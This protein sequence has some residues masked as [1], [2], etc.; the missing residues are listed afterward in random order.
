VEG[1]HDAAAKFFAWF[2][3]K[4]SR[5]SSQVNGRQRGEGVSLGGFYF[6]DLDGLLS[7]CFV[8]CCLMCIVLVGCFWSI[9]S[10]FY[11]QISLLE[12]SKKKRKSYTT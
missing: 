6:V 9:Y 7:C 4:K 12:T 10:M 8:F 3:R 1:E 2:W 11:M 5:M